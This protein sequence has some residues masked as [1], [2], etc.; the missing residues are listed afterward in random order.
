MRKF[1]LASILC[2]SACSSDELKPFTSDGCSSFPDG[3]MQQQSLWLSCCVKHDLSYWKGGTYQE[4]LDADLSLEQCVADIGEPKV[5]K[6][7]LAGVR[8]GGSPYW[9]TTYRWGY[10]WAYPRGYK[11]LTA[12]DKQKIS[13][14]LTDLELMLRSLQREIQL[15]DNLPN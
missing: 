11:A 1:V 2:L 14:R 6:L 7:M 5:A 8:V 13:Q 10:G 15:S 12:A 9:P 4:R 3:T